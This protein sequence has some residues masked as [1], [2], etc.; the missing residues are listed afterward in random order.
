MHKRSLR[1]SLVYPGRCGR[2]EQDCPQRQRSTRLASDNVA[3]A[4]MAWHD[5]GPLS[6]IAK[7]AGVST[8]AMAPAIVGRSGRGSGAGSMRPC[9][10]GRRPASTGCPTRCWPGERPSNT[11]SGPSRPGWGHPLPDPDA[12][13]RTEMSLLVLAY[14]IK[15]MISIFGVRPRLAAVR[16]W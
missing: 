10:T 7:I 13:V 8:A 2:G 3:F 15:R 6:G 1:L 11:R 4:A 16:A 5:E 12:Q 9:S 14:N